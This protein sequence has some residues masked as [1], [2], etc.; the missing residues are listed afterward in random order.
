MGK[1]LVDLDGQIGDMRRAYEFLFQKG[2][3]EDAFYKIRHINA[4]LPSAARVEDMPYLKEYTNNFYD[5]QERPDY[6]RNMCNKW[7]EIVNLAISTF[8]ENEIEVMNR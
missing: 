1:V 5:I 8:R 4:S 7:Y 2:N 6:C 3:F